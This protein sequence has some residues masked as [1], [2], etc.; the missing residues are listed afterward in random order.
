MT[1]DDYL[2]VILKG[3]VDNAD[4]L[5]KHFYRECKEAEAKHIDY[6][7]FFTRLMKAY[8][9]FIQDRDKRYY[10]D[11]DRMYY[12]LIEIYHDK[13]AAGKEVNFTLEQIEQQKPIKE[14]ISVHLFSFT[15]GKYMGN[16]SSNN[17]DYIKSAIAE[18][19]VKTDNENQP[20]KD[21]TKI[22]QKKKVQTL[23]ETWTKD[24]THYNKVIEYLKEIS[25]TVGMSFC[26]LPIF[27]THQK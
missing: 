1:Q 24:E 10:T 27:S 12:K 21:E 18:A 9:L 25:P 20:A 13:K 16:L 7:E 17:L 22:K 23:F 26:R 11:L 4:N 19:F 3:Y 6:K 2:E 15:N 14:N 5:D 8:D